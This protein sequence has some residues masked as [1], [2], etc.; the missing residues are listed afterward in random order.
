MAEEDSSSQ[1]KYDVFLSFRGSDVRRN[2]VSHLYEAL[3]NEGIETFHDDRELRKGEFIWEGLEKAMNQS[4]FAI[5][6]ISKEYASSHWCLKEISVM[7]DLAEKKRLE[8][9]PIFYDIDPSDLKRRSGCFNQAFE[10]HELRY[11]LEMVGKWRRALAQ[12]GNISGWDSKTSKE[13]S[14]LVRDIVQDLSERLYSN[15]PG[16]TTGLVGMSFHK[17]NMETFLSMESNDVRMVGV[18]GMGGRGKTTIAKYVFDDISSQFD[19]CCLQDNVKGDFKQYGVSHLR[20]EIMSKFFPKSRLNAQSSDA[21][22]RKLRGKVLLVLDDVDDIQQLQELAG[23]WFGSGSRIVITTRDKRVLDV[24]GVIHIYEV[25]PLRPTLALQLFSEHAFRMNRPQEEFRTLSLDIVEQLGGLPLALRVI[26]ASLYQREIKFWKEKLMRRLFFFMLLVVSMVNIWI[27]RKRRLWVHDLLQDMAKDIICDGKKEK[28]WKRKMLYS[29]EDFKGLFA[30]NMGTK[31]IE[32]ESISLNMAEET[33]LYINP[34]MFRRML[35]LKFLKIHNNLTVGG[36]KICMVNNLEYLPPLRYLHWEV[37]TLRSLPSH[38][39]T[40]YLVELNLPDSSVE[41]LWSGTQDLRKLRH[42][43]LNRC[44]QL[45]EIPDL[46]KAKSLETLCLCDCESLVELHSSLWHLNGL[47]KL[48]MRNCTKLKNLPRNISL[49]SLKTLA[50]DGCTSIED[51][52]FIS[53]NIEQLGLSRTSI[54]IVPTS[55]ERLSRL[56]D[57]RLSQCKRLKNLPVTLG[58]LESLKNL[59]ITNCPK[60]TVFPVLGNGIEALALNGTAIEEVPSTI[61]DKLN[62]VFLDMTDCQRLQNFPPALINLKKLK[63]L[64]LRGCTNI[65]E[66]PQIAGEMRKLDLYGTSIK[67]YGFLSEDEALELRKRDMDFVKGF[68]TRYVRKYK[69]NKNSR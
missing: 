56:T 59:W 50:L 67:K 63:F 57:L 39:Q 27:E 42:L 34:A 23:N 19:V 47:V 5:V 21:M 49:E 64:Y 38:F 28:P 65:T 55:I 8:L 1:W 20:K 33:E 40:E 48:S 7:V 41:R 2:L 52:P 46:S 54:E 36:S 51:F 61:G 62:L 68:L 4:R 44:R 12:V 35:N 24:H 25:K 29:F 14:E 15:S 9:I 69:K 53:D 13:D 60:V 3:T 43:N 37:Y 31:D 18:W 32:V 17:K 11:D 26:G 58:G 16:E 30:E 45:I 10:K 22:K 6:V 66:L